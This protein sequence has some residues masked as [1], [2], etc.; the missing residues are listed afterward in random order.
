MSILAT[1]QIT[2]VD[3]NDQVSLSSYIQS[4]KPKV[5]FATSAGVINPAWTA[6]SPLTLT[7]ELYK[8]G[9]TSN[10]I[11]ASNEVSKIQ[12][13]KRTTTDPDWIEITAAN[14]G[15]NYEFV[16]TAPKLTGLKVKNNLMSKNGEHS[17]SFQ[18]RIT[19]KEAWMPVGSEHTQVS[20][21]DFTLAVQG[22]QGTDAYTVILTNESHSLLATTNGSVASNEFGQSSRSMCDVI[23]YKG[24]V[25]LPAGNAAG[26]GHFYLKTLTPHGCTISNNTSSFW[27]TGMT[28]DIGYVDVV[29]NVD[30]AQDITKRMSIT[31]VKAGQSAKMLMVTGE[32]IFKYSAGYVGTPTPASLT[33]TCIRQLVTS[34][35]WQHYVS[36]NSEATRWQ[37]FSPAQTGNSITIA[38]DQAGTDFADPANKQLRIRCL[39]TDL[40]STTYDEMTLFKISDGVSGVDAYTVMLT[41]ESHSITANHD[42]S[43]PN[44]NGAVT[45]IVVYKGA[46][47][48]GNIT[49][50]LG[51]PTPH[52]PLINFELDSALHTVKLTSYGAAEPSNVVSLPINITVDGHTFTKIFTVTRTKAGADGA[53]SLAI[54]VTGQQA[55]VYDTNGTV[56]NSKITLTANCKNFV[57]GAS[58]IKWQTVKSGTVSKTITATGGTTQDILPTGA[59]YD[60]DWVGD[61]LTIRATYVVDAN[62]YD[63]FTIHRV[64]SAKSALMGYIWCP[65]GNVIKNF[66]PGTGQSLDNQNASLKLEAHAMWG[67]VDVSTAPGITYT[68]YKIS[69]SQGDIEIKDHG[70]GAASNQCIIHASDIPSM[71]RVKCKITYSGQTITDTA[72]LQDLSDP[73]QCDILSVNGEIFKNKQGVTFLIAK[74]FRGGDQYD[75]VEFHET[76]PAAPPSAS[77][78]GKIIYVQADEKYYKGASG[79]W[80]PLTTPPSKSDGNALFNYVWFKYD[81][82]GGQIKDNGGLPVYWS[83]KIIK[84]T[85]NDIDQ[86]ATYVVEISD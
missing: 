4:S 6:A 85:A 72:V 49:I 15:T 80:T 12:W 22:E 8:I 67:D 65:D 11:I 43:S 13:F 37:D 30:G 28:E 35:K 27:L 33:L 36:G 31:K 38:P 81:A 18:V 63:D 47:Q 75:T 62:I 71:L 41:N 7:A 51:T 68:W 59:A 21:I 17:V 82:N 42:G 20:E 50:A 39:D 1:S 32:Q 58:G 48:V 66:N 23:V 3:L 16:G 74:V 9:A 57:P 14:A 25:P 54:D 24:G 29:I 76:H 64:H 56:N 19:Y 44:L 2:I 46:T 78:I 34:I 73:Y 70:V 61:A 69:P 45:G 79:S 10:N 83:G 52:S 55:F 5:Q 84:V 40:S 60:S 53:N 77:E 26:T 86:K